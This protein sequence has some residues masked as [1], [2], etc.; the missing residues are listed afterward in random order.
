MPSLSSYR[1]GMAFA[2][3]PPQRPRTSLTEKR[4]DG[5]VLEKD[6]GVWIQTCT[7]QCERGVAAS[8]TI[9]DSAVAIQTNR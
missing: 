1:I 4:P 5:M 3:L 7:S 8:V 2:N 6:E 9:V